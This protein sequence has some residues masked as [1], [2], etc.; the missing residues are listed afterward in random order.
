[1]TVSHRMVCSIQN[2][3]GFSWAVNSTRTETGKQA[4]AS[5]WTRQNG[6]TLMVHLY[7]SD[8][9]SIL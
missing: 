4:A 3:V 5:Q 9:H 8:S 1:M 2:T 6:H 7:L